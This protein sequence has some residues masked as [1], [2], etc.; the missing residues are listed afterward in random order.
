[1]SDI[2]FGLIIA[3][4]A[5]TAI[6]GLLAVFLHFDHRRF[7]YYADYIRRRR[8]PL[9]RDRLLRKIWRES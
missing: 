7:R 3:A 9:E 6:L 4:I 5:I 8:W 1:M 2:W